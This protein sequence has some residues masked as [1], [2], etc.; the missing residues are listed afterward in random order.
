MRV[1]LAQINPTVG[2][3]DGNAAKVAEWIGRAREAGA[4]L[5]IF[6]E[7]CI[8]GY[9]AEDLYLK[10]HFLRANQRAVEEL[11]A[12]AQGITALVG[13]AE[14]VADLADAPPRLQLDRGPRRRRDRGRLPQE[15]PP[16]LRA[17][18]TS[19]ATSSPAP[20]RRRSRSTALG[21]RPDDLRGR[22][23]AGAAGRGGGRGRRAADRQ[24][25]GLPLPPRQGPRAGGDVRRALPRLR[26]LLRLLQP[27]RRPGRARLRRP[28]P[29][30]RPRRQRHRPRRPVRGG[31]AGLRGPPRRA[32]TAG[33]AARRP[34]RGLRGADPRPP[35]LRR[36]E[37]LRA[38]RRRPLRRDR[39]GAGR[40]ARRRRGRA[41][42][43]HL[44][45]HALPPLQRR[46]PAGRPRHRRQPR[47]RA[48]RD[49]D[50]ADDGELRAG[51]ERLPG[52]ARRRR[53]RA[54]RPNPPSPT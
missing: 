51:A 1:A 43:A 44:R 37:R 19:S 13:F 35:R 41:G 34:R 49:R 15:P 4:E 17:S 5:V 7:L 6:P 28:E 47:L 2:D 26:R 33:R 18:S 8:P 29:R 11:A 22:L 42:A 36:Q 21:G 32:G 50:R 27:G 40:D 54:T 48:D 23:G 20:S 14:P 9:P 53:C 31:A 52:R 3:V 25:L 38:R 16:Q 45:R 12:S 10:R 39:L 46:D 24:P 30:H